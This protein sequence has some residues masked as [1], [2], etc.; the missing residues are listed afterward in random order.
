METRG[1]S[2][3]PSAF[4]MRSCTP[5]YTTNLVTTYGTSLRR[6]G[7]RPLYSE[8][9]PPSSRE[10]RSAATDDAPGSARARAHDDLA[11]ARAQARARARARPRAV[12]H[13]PAGA[14]R[15]RFERRGCE[16]PQRGRQRSHRQRWRVR[17][18]VRAAASRRTIRCPLPLPHQACARRPGM[19]VMPKCGWLGCA[20]LGAG[21][22]GATRPRPDQTRASRRARSPGASRPR[23]E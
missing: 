3:E 11:W 23:P 1:V 19:R 5:S 9:K 10:D 22:R 12:C 8:P 17:P 21:F 6:M 16:R 7:P 13:E 4:T 14:S 15:Y 18:R 2:G 20:G